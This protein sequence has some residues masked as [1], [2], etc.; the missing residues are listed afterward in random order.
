MIARLDE[1][2]GRLVHGLAAI[3][4]CGLIFQA[5]AIVAD[6]VSRWLFNAPILGMEDI[7]GLL[8]VVI[9]ASFFPA[10]LYDRGNIAIDVVGR[11]FGK[12]G[13]EA[14]NAFGHLVTLAFFIIL[15]WQLLRHTE[16]VSQRITQI[17]ELPVQ[18]MW[19]LATAIMFFAVPIQLLVFIVHLHAA[20]T[21]EVESDGGFEPLA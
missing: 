4:L 7:N 12:R 21:G 1:W 2:A 17:L 9:V 10:V 20:I 18:P 11:M 16:D 15:A 6:V 19:W 5:V 13:A 8:I 3:G 14:L